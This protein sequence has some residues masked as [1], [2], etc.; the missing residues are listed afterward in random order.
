MCTMASSSTGVSLFGGGAELP[1]A[2]CVHGVSI[3]L[4]V[5][6]THQLDAVDRAIAANHGV[7]HDFPFHALFDQCGRI[8]RIDLPERPRSRKR[9]RKPSE[10]PRNSRAARRKFKIQLPVALFRLGHV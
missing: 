1:L 5:D 9:P 10:G 4:L 6:A 7:E 8:L 2:Q 3:Q